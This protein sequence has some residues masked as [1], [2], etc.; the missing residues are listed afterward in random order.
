MQNRTQR[1]V[2]A[3][4]GLLALAGGAMLA[5]AQ[6]P[7][8]PIAAL[9]VPNAEQAGYTYGVNFGSQLNSLGITPNDIPLDSVMRGFK[10]GLAGKKTTPADINVVQQFIQDLQKAVLAKNRSAAKDFLAHNASQKGVKTTASGL[11]YKIVTAGNTKASSPRA[12]DTV[13]VQYRGTLI[14]GKEFDSS[15]ARNQ[16]STFAL[17]GVIKGWQEALVLMKPG[18]K[19]Q[20]FVP[21]ELAYDAALKQGIPPGSLL[22]FDVELVSIAPTIA[23][24]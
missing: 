14:D 15:Y 9:T 16:P 18:A 21:P 1:V 20:I 17:A 3:T 22:I 2:L 11:Q 19:W 23:S 7:A 13:T 12:A 4:C 24:N 8:Q 10:D 5:T 6:T